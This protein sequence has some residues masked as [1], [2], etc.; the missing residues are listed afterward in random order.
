M[1][2]A[3]SPVACSSIRH[4]YQHQPTDHSKQ[5]PLEI[6]EFGQRKALRWAWQ[7][8]NV[9]AVVKSGAS[10]WLSQH[11]LHN[12]TREVSLLP[13][14]IHAASFVTHAR[15]RSQLTRSSQSISLLRIEQL[16]NAKTTAHNE[17]KPIANVLSESRWWN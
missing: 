11:D 6:C 8:G 4:A 5:H 16:I 10:K 14:R 15:R 7:Q 3:L 1:A 13:Q 12:V 17:I 2:A 9:A